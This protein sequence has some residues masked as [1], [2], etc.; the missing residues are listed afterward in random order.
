MPPR[1][2]L[3]VIPL[4]LAFGC[5]GLV[6]CDVNTSATTGG[7]KVTFGSGFDNNS[8]SVTGQTDTFTAGD[9]ITWVAKLS[10]TTGSTDV[11]SLVEHQ[12]SA[13]RTIF[14][15]QFTNSNPSDNELSNTYDTSGDAAGQ[16]T[17]RVIKGDN[18]I[19]S[20]DYSLLAG[21]SSGSQA[22]PTPAAQQNTPTPGSQSTPTPNSQTSSPPSGSITLLS[23]SA[24]QTAPTAGS[25]V[26]LDYRVE[27]DT[28][29]SAQVFLGA[30]IYSDPDG[31][32]IDDPADDAVVTAQPGVNVYQR[33]FVFPSTASGSYDLLVS[34]DDAAHVHIYKLLRYNGLFT[35]A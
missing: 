16:Y 28:G 24:E 3:A 9:K 26:T 31:T 27:N 35:V 11:L 8:F 10:D 2:R 30:T 18:I 7:G 21:S 17:M 5:L 4:A 33:Q 22:T 14:S 15:R 25:S 34:L 29:S 13:E 20:G 19:A 32:S 12:G 23:A 1:L 6:G